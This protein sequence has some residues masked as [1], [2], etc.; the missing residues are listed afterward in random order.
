MTMGNVSAKIDCLKPLV[1]IKNTTLWRDKLLY[2]HLLNTSFFAQNVWCIYN[3][4]CL[5]CNQ[6]DK[7]PQVAALLFIS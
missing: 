5:R 6:N 2:F 4:E 7:V 1:K 3:I